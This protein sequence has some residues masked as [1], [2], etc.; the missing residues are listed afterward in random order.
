MSCTAIGIIDWELN[1]TEIGH[2]N[3][4]VTWLVQSDSPGLDG[5]EQ[6]MLASGLPGI[7]SA[8][9][10]GNE[11]DAWALCWPNFKTRQVYSHEPCD[12]WTVETY[13]STQPIKRCMNTQIENPL[14]EPFKISGSFI[15]RTKIPKLDMNGMP[16]TNS[17]QQLLSSSELEFDNNRPTIHVAWNQLLNPGPTATA[18][19]DTVNDAPMW[20]W[21]ARCLKLNSCQFQRQLWGICNFY[22]TNQYEIGVMYDPYDLNPFGQPLGWDRLVPDMG[23]RVLSGWSPGYWTDKPDGTKN[24]PPMCG[25]GVTTGCR[26][27]PLAID[28]TTG[29]EYYLNPQNYEAYKMSYDGEPSSTYLFNGTPVTDGSLAQQIFI[30]YYPSNNLL[31]LGLPTDINVNMFPGF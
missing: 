5:P 12:L 23:N 25:V 22:F 4:S 6:A 20:G 14:M 31:A 27:N 13:F 1:M 24:I 26:L 10:Y 15:Q 28:P 29:K 9:I 2:R 16:I 19:I 11:N 18:M 3:Y 17:A 21:P 30:Q 7:G 8:W